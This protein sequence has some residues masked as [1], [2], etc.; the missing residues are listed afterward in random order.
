MNDRTFRLMELHQKLDALLLQA[1]RRRIANPLEIARLWQR[2]LRLRNRL[3]ALL[4]RPSGAALPS[5]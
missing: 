5:L 2:K 4:E 1:R 3:A